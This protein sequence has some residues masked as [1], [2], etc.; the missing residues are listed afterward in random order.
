MSGG[1]L[2]FLAIFFPET[3]GPTVSP[4]FSHNEPG[5][6]RRDKI[7]HK[8]MKRLRK[9]T[10]NKDLVSQAQLDAKD[11]KPSQ[12]AYDTLVRPIVLFREPI[13]LVFNLY[14]ALIYGEQP[15]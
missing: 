3:S 7:L 4:S 10:G 14:L 12:L 2:V 11:T 5:S 15:L 6:S 1:V 9:A 8:R 13:L